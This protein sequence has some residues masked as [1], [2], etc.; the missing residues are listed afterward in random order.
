MKCCVEKELSRK[1][2]E[3]GFMISICLSF[4]YLSSQGQKVN[5]MSYQNPLPYRKQQAATHH[6]LID[7]VS[8]E[9]ERTMN[10]T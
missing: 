2:F 5:Y 6:C 1:I 4:V 10:L 9:Q 7:P 8:G 3:A